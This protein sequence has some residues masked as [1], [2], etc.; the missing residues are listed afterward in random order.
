MGGRAERTSPSAAREHVGAVAP[1]LI[2]SYMRAAER[3]R[4]RCVEWPAPSTERCHLALSTVVA[5]VRVDGVRVRIGG[6]HRRL[7]KSRPRSHV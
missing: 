5:R 3:L 1:A 6:G 4:H 2:V 7:A